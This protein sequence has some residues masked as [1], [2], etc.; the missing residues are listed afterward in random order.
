MGTFTQVVCLFSIHFN[1]SSPT[2]T[3]SIEHTNISIPC[4]S[5]MSELLLTQRDLRNLQFKY[6]LLKDQQ[7]RLDD[8][9]LQYDIIKEQN[10]DLKYR[11]SP[12]YQS[13]RLKEA[14]LY[15]RSIL[16]D[17]EQLFVDA[18]DVRLENQRL[19]IRVKELEE[20][21]QDLSLRVSALEWALKLEQDRWHIDSQ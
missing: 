15:G 7:K 12:D 6:N 9:Q 11:L 13:N 20:V 17:E 16:T 19:R 8:L 14:L 10:K 2:T 18:S 5:I 4:F 3:P 21:N 1:N